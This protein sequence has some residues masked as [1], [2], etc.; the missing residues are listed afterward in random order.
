MKITWIGLIFL[1]SLWG[2]EG[3]PKYGFSEEYFNSK[4]ACWEYFDMHPSFE[5][6]AQHN[7]LYHVH[8]T[9]KKYEIEEVGT[10]YVTCKKKMFDETTSPWPAPTIDPAEPDQHNHDHE[11]NH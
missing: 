3:G 5:L 4:E 1:I 11:H 7:N 9:I 2:E 8:T 10:A 6:L